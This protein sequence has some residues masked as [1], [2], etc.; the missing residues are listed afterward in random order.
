MDV[1]YVKVPLSCRKFSD[2]R[3]MVQTTQGEIPVLFFILQF[4][5]DKELL[6]LEEKFA[7]Y[8]V[9]CKESVEELVREAQEEMT[10]SGKIVKDTIVFIVEDLTV[11]NTTVKRF[12]HIELGIQCFDEVID[13]DQFNTDHTEGWEQ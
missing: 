12:A 1:R 6:T 10:V 9:Q 11:F 3:V 13:L 5:E 7:K 2:Y 8:K 4:E